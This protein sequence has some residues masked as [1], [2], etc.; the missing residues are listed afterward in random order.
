MPSAETLPSVT[1]RVTTVRMTRPRTSSATAA[2]STVRASTRRE[3]AQVAED[4]SGDAHARRGERGADE[5]RLLARR[6][7][8]AS[9]ATAP[10][11]IG[12]TTPTIATED[13]SAPDGSQLAQVHLEPDLEQEQDHAQLRERAG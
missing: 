3:R 9:P 8:V 10:V 11:A 12:T 6:T 7:R 13:R 4:A 1:M 5:H 2:P